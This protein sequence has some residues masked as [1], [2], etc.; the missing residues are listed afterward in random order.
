MNVWCSS[1]TV[2]ACVHKRWWATH[3]FSLFFFQIGEHSTAEVECQRKASFHNEQAVWFE[4]RKCYAAVSQS[5]RRSCLGKNGQW[6]TAFPQPA[7]G[8]QI[9]LSIHFLIKSSSA[10]KATTSTKTSSHVKKE[11][12]NSFSN[13]LSIHVSFVAPNL[14]RLAQSN[15]SHQHLVRIFEI[16]A[17]PDNCESEYA[18][19]LCTNAQDRAPDL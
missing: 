4:I 18:P 2:C 17:A 19:Q 15:V 12:I 13:N 5:D 14:T 11:S 7:E 16:G 6:C 10:Q 3:T 8:K 9:I 1:W